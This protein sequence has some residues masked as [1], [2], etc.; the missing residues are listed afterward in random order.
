[1][2]NFLFLFFFHVCVIWKLEISIDID[3]MLYAMRIIRIFKCVKLMVEPFIIII[4]INFLFFFFPFFSLLFVTFLQDF[5]PLHSKMY[6]HIIWQFQAK[7]IWEREKSS[8]IHTHTHIR[9]FVTFWTLN[10]ELI[11][12][13]KISPKPTAQNE[14]MDKTKN[15]RNEYERKL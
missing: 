7:I 1:M 14:E 15:R 10:I 4:I 13:G 11:I 12:N 6:I 3:W 2:H 9:Q 5:S 8:I